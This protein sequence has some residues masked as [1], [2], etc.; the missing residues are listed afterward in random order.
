[1]GDKFFTAII[2]MMFTAVLGCLFYLMDNTTKSLDKLHE[3]VAVISEGQFSNSAECYKS[4]E[5]VPKDYRARGYELCYQIEQAKL[6][7]NTMVMLAEDK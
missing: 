2:I 3:S 5:S 6:A 1:M 4:L 7:V